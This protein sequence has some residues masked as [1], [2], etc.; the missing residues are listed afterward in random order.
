MVEHQFKCEQPCDRFVNNRNPD[1]SP[2][3]Y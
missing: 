2:S 1:Q 3:P